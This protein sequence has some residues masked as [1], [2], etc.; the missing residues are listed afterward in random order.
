MPIDVIQVSQ[1]I[2]ETIGPIFCSLD[3]EKLLARTFHKIQK[4]TYLSLYVTQ[5][6]ALQNA[7]NKCLG[8]AYCFKEAHNINIVIVSP[9]GHGLYNGKNI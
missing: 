8:F 9:R 1:C 2:H 3:Y 4:N 7:H 5:V 6:I